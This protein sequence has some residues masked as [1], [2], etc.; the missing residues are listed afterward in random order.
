[1]WGKK[2]K[3]QTKNANKSL[4]LFAAT[5]KSCLGEISFNR[6]FCL[7]QLQISS[8]TCGIHKT[9]QIMHKTQKFAVTLT[10]EDELGK[11]LKN[12]RQGTMLW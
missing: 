2:R 7:N 6:H 4:L 5:R 8:P 1:L 10:I 9:G 3:K 11:T 12:R